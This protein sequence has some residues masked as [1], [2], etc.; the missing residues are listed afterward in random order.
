MKKLLLSFVG[1]FVAGVAFAQYTYVDINQISFVS[2][3]DLQS[4]NDSSAYLGDTVITRGIV[5]T[6]G[7][8]SEVSSSSVTGGSRPF[9]AI[10]DTANGGAQGAFSSITVMGVNAGTSNPNNGIENALAGDII[11]MTCI[12]SEFAGGIQLQPL[13][14]TSVSIV[15]VGTPPASV[16]VPVSDLQDN[17]RVN[18]LATGEQWEGAYVE[19][20]NVTVTGVS[21]FSGGNRTEITVE[22]A[23]GNQILIADRYLGMKVSGVSTTNPNSPL[24]AGNFVAPSIG[25]VFNFIRGIVVQDENGPCYPNASSFAG[26][27]EINPLDSTD[28]D[29]AAS[30]ANISSVKRTPLVPNAS[31]TVNVTADIIDNDGTVTS[32]TLFYTADQSAPA[33]LFTSLLMTNTSGSIYTATI[34]AFA[35]DSIVRYFI[36]AVDDSMNVTTSPNTPTGATL[37]TDFYTVRSNGATIM[38]IQFTP[39]LSNGA[40]PLVGDTVTV[41]G[42]VTSSFQ[43]GDLGFL[44]IQDPTANEFS[45]VYVDGGPV[46]VF[47]LNRGDEVTVEGVVDEAFGFTRLIAINVTATGNTGTITPVV[48]DP[49]D[50]NLFGSGAIDIEKYE[51][52]LLRYENPIMGAQVWVANPNLGFGEYSV[53]SGFQPTTAARVLAG[54]QVA[55]QAQGSLEV[56]Y[57]SDT[58]QYG[59]GLNVTPIQMTTGFSMDAL[60]GILYYAFGYYKLTPR[61]NA[62]FSNIVVSVET[63]FD[64]NVPTLVYPNPAEDRVMVQIDEDYRFNQVAIQVLDITGRIVLDTRSSIALNS[65]NLSG[66]DKG[67]YII[68]ITNSDELIHSSKLIL[69]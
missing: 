54:R 9:I 10:A 11:E 56:S 28:F 16:V 27:Y 32:A 48:L 64:A 58:A 25:T 33:N 4:C 62:D 38:D 52:M 12:V 1:L 18:K 34:P 59:A 40:S 57:I 42:I 49:S 30:P 7:N 35:L 29:K 21:V 47:S 61:N 23:A 31:Q 45:G 39:D 63:I 66:L 41:T 65:I 22:D 55:G 69:K 53:G 2:Q 43:P 26:G 24:A 51:G 19:I 67:M 17:M 5:I 14:S 6:D 50:P 36:V 20:Q 68:R 60:E 15:G 13:S 44:Y 46:S 3:A 8:L 37:R